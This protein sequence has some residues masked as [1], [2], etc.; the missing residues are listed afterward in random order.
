MLLLVAE[1]AEAQL[2]AIND[3]DLSPVSGT[4]ANQESGKPKG[5]SGVYDFTP[6][7]SGSMATCSP[8]SYCNRR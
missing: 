3:V 6:T 5:G 2:L 8:R 1:Q 4:G 7:I